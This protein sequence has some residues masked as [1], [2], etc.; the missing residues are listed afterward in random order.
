MRTLILAACACVAA[1]PALA[2]QEP[3]PGKFDPR[4]VTV[5]YNPAQ[6]YA[7]H[8]PQ[9]QTLAITLAPDEIA[10]DGFGADNKSL[11]SDVSGNT[12]LLWSSDNTSIA[13]RSMFI[14]SRVPIVRF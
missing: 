9:G 1:V 14:R 2:L 5:D 13:P 11:R 8:I 6:V 7:V 12:V 3:T 10:T 4:M